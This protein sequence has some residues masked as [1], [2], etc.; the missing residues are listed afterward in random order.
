MIMPLITL[1]RKRI[2]IDVDTQKHFFTSASSVCVRNHR[3]VFANILRIVNWARHQKIQ[4]LS[5]V[6]ILGDESHLALPV[7]AIE[8]YN[9]MDHTKRKRCNTFIAD[10][11]TDIPGGLFEHHDQVILYKRCFDPFREP[12]ADRILTEIKA[13]EFILI[14]TPTEAAVKATALGLLARQKN[15]TVV[16]DAT[17]PLGKES[18]EIALRTIQ[19]RGVRLSRTRDLMAFSCIELP[20][21][22]NIA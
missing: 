6:Q 8:G 13:S 12:K 1:P 4:L 17:G 21:A 22:I 5:T 9:K 3:R 2:I 20:E 11:R 10:D 7:T 19:E 16:T 15:V 18:G 14:G